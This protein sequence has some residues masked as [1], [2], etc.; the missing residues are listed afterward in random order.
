MLNIVSRIIAYLT[1]IHTSKSLESLMKRSMLWQHVCSRVPGNEKWEKLGT[2][3]HGS[4]TSMDLT[5]K[6]GNC[7]FGMSWL[8]NIFKLN[9]TIITLHITVQL[10]VTFSVV[11]FLRHSGSTWLR[12]K[13]KQKKDDWPFTFSWNV[14]QSK[15]R[16]PELQTLHFIHSTLIYMTT[17]SQ[18]CFRTILINLP[19]SNKTN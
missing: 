3:E 17:I 4:S 9:D 16:K 6:N 1:L 10:I 11:L 12:N 8:V 15:L 14:V 19:N 5:N 18:S 13:T 2:C 7:N